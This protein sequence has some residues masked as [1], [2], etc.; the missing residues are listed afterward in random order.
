MADSF[1]TIPH[2]RVQI[3]PDRMKGILTAD[4]VQCSTDLLFSR[5]SVMI[6]HI[7]PDL[8]DICICDCFSP[9]FPADI[10]YDLYL[11]GQ[12]V[13]ADTAS[14]NRIL[15]KHSHTVLNR[16]PWQSLFGLFQFFCDIFHR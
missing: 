2:Q 9:A 3:V 11:V 1:H 4:N 8:I 5:Q 13:P 15:L 10:L 12:L 16:L 14:K 7:K 6:F